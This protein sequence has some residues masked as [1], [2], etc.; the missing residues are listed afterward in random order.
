MRVSLG[1]A[2]LCLT[3]AATIGA[4]LVLIG[5]KREFDSLRSQLEANRTKLVSRGLEIVNPSGQVIAS[6]TP[7]GA[8][9]EG[10]KLNL[11]SYAPS[12][13]ESSTVTLWAQDNFGPS[14]GFF[15]GKKPGAINHDSWADFTSDGYSFGHG[16]GK[17]REDANVSASLQLT[18]TSASQ[19]LITHDVGKIMIGVG[20][21][22]AEFTNGPVV[23]QPA[24]IFMTALKGDK[25]DAPSMNIALSPKKDGTSEP[26]IFMIGHNWTQQANFSNEAVSLSN[27]NQ[28]PVIN[29]AIENDGGKLELNDQN[30]AGSVAAGTDPSND[31][32]VRFVDHESK[33][34]G[35]AAAK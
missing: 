3:I 28:L 27:R 29:L 12:S 26:D 33:T 13:A 22:E 2:N 6:L 21:G 32:Y 23:T 18:E 15:R 4:T 30:G 16:D 25:Y 10:A 9:Q 5:Q 34:A 24:G 11:T 14:L 19:A 17:D 8:N 31:G 7:D 20:D 35:P 1:T